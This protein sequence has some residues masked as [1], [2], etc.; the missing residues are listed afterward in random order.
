MTVEELITELQ[1]Y[2]KDENVYVYL[3]DKKIYCPDIFVHGKLIDGIE[4]TCYEEE[5]VH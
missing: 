5:D 2:P 1:K 3:Q 4:I